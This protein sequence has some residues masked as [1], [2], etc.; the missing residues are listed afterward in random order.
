MVLFSKCRRKDGLWIEVTSGVFVF[1]PRRCSFGSRPAALSGPITKAP[2]FAGG[3]LP[4]C[5]FCLSPSHTRLSGASGARHSLRPPIGE[6]G[7]FS[8]KLGRDLRR[9]IAES[10]RGVI[11]S[12]SEAIHSGGEARIASSQALLAMTV[13]LAL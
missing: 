1:W 7:K 8:A 12:A 13:V 10:Y 2:G 4:A 9:E 3:Y 6:G 5:A 11:A